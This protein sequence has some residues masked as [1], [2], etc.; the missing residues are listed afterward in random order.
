MLAGAASSAANRKCNASVV[1]SAREHGHGNARSHPIMK[2]QGIPV[3]SSS[4]RLC[5]LARIVERPCNLEEVRQRGSARCHPGWG[6]RIRTP[7]FRI[8]RSSLARTCHMIGADLMAPVKLLSSSVGALGFDDDHSE[9]KVSNPPA[10]A[11][12][13]GFSKERSAK[14]KAAPPRGAR[15]WQVLQLIR[16]LSLPV[17]R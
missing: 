3:V 16:G 13:S 15:P 6:G 4:A 11:R 7:A 14:S 8:T 5:R 17:P 10:P 2:W 1:D 12:Q 9:C